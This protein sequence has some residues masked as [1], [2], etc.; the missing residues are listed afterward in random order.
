MK[1]ERRRTSGRYGTSIMQCNE[2][3]S[4]KND[5]VPDAN[6]GPRGGVGLGEK[7][8]DERRGGG[9]GERR[10]DH[11]FRPRLPRSPRTA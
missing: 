1:G 10:R 2:Q 7:G 5:N 4:A 9:G 3:L 6:W 11:L 8:E